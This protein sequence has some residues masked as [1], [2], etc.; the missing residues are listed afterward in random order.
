MSTRLRFTEDQYVL[1]PY[2]RKEA[3]VEI[4][5]DGICGDVTTHLY[6]SKAAKHEYKEDFCKAYYWNCP[7]Y[8]SLEED[9]K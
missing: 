1:C 5:C 8:R 2:Y 6:S 3:A 7:C 9:G 4:R